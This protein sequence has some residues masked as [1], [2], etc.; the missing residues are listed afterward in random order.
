MPPDVITRKEL[1][2]TRGT[3]LS[4]ADGAWNDEPKPRCDVGDRILFRQYAGEMLDVEGQ[5]K[6]RIINDKDVYAVL[7]RE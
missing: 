7:E 6:F 4:I 1:A 5:D 2:Q 3:V